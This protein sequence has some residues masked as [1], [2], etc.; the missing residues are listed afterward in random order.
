MAVLLA[1]WAL[2]WMLTPRTVLD[3]PWQ[4]FA[5][6]TSMK[7]LVWIALGAA[8]FRPEGR[9]GWLGEYRGRVLFV[10]MLAIAWAA[11][12]V[13]AVRLGLKPAPASPSASSSAAAVWTAWLTVLGIA[14]LLEELL[15]R[16]LFWSALASAKLRVGVVWVVSASAFAALH[17]PGWIATQGV[18]P[19]LLTQFGLVF[20]AGLFFGLGRWLTGS[21]WSAVFLHF[22]NNAASVGVFNS[23]IGATL[24]A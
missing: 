21:L 2:A 17:L 22:V 18:S 20:A 3:G 16:G 15:F 14:P 1:T 4:S 12:D 19:S 13:V 5:W 24:E 9:R 10:V 11:F 7:G 6:W 23:V 8:L